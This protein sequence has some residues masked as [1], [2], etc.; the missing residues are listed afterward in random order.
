MSTVPEVIA[1]N[2]MGIKVC[3]VSCVAN[4]AAG[5]T[6]ERLSEAEVLTEMGRASDRLVKLLESFVS[7]NVKQ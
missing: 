5:M 7:L 6:S 3:A 4:Y 1:A 2:H